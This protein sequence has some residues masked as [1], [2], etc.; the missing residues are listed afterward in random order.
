[1]QARVTSAEYL[2]GLRVRI[3]FSDGLVRELD[4]GGV[5][6]RGVLAS[7]DDPALFAQ[8]QV[9]NVAGTVRWPNGVDLDP[10]VLHGDHDPVSGNAPRV[11][12]E[13]RL[14]TAS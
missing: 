12:K 8:V 3:S 9:D 11:L 13:Y 4:F 7:L 5:F 6:D 2:G 1:M 10:D 14:H